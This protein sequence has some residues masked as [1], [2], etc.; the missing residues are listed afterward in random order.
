MSDSNFNKSSKKISILILIIWILVLIING[1]LSIKYFENSIR[2]L[3]TIIGLILISIIEYVAKI[4][5]KSKITV[6]LRRIFAIPFLI[7]GFNWITIFTLTTYRSHHRPVTI[8]LAVI[9]LI[10]GLMLTHYKIYVKSAVK[11]K[12]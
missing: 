4:Q 9:F 2:I 7:L 3:I 11:I 12:H 5:F 8:P 1:F 6:F 10:I